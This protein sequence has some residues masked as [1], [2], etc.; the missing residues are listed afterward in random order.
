MFLERTKRFLLGEPLSNQS[1]SGEKIP[2]WKALAVLSSDALSS[3]AYATEEIIIPLVAF[4]VLALAW[5]VPVSL[6]IVA[7]LLIVST[8]YRQTIQAYPNGGGAYV[9]AKE[10]LGLQSGLIA[11]AALLIGYILTVSV[12][13]SAGVSAITSAFPTLLPYRVGIGLVLIL[14]LTIMNLRGIRESASIFALPTYFFLFMMLSMIAYGLLKVLFGWEVDSAPAPTQPIFHESYA[15]V[16]L[17]LILRAFSSGCAALTGIEAISNGVP[18]F[19][20]PPEKN[21]KSTLTTMAV[22]LCILFF[23]ITALIQSYEI[24]P[25]ADEAAIS[26]LARAVFGEGILYYLLQASTALILIL[27]AN[28][29]YN[30][31]PW[32][33]AILAKDRHLPRQLAILGDKLVYSNSIIWLS[34]VAGLLLI[35]FNGDTHGLI[36]LYALGV[37]LGFTL[38][39]L[40][41]LR[42]HLRHKNQGWI[43]GFSINL[44]GAATTF[45]VMIVVGMTKFSQGAWIV[46]VLIPLVVLVLK[47]IHQHYLDVG[48]ELTLLGQAAP[49]HLDP[50]KH[51]VIV[52]IS[53][54]HRG[55]IEALRYAVSISD[56]VRA[57]YVEIDPKSTERM[58]TV[59]EQ[60]G[61]DI[62][63]VV[64]KS[65]F[66]SIIRPLLDYIDDLG[67]TTPNELVTVVI[68]EFV[69]AK[70]YHRFLHN[71][72]AL[73]IRA[74]LL[75]KKNRVVTSVRYHLKST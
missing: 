19:K 75:F 54:V 17:F 42:H 9:V 1:M 74:A 47:R 15:A 53:G 33:A 61:R 22:L 11:G 12:S 29:S 21:A 28:T 3:V 63:F 43:K 67:Q 55:V 73:I 37:F 66:R 32:L 58:E 41:M 68:P 39:Q 50:V 14:L 31:F 52:P 72:T 64:L 20:D 27:A 7:L 10:N 62:P 2:R 34:I 70:W 30:G 46:I 48:K 65:P 57:C 8:S 36:P 60:W 4:S 25:R 16:P 38:S 71:Q 35:L 49:D 51:T 26:Q 69:T 23:G 45:V 13:V 40:G 59:W 18:A 24:L 56:D 44:L 5:S 6:G